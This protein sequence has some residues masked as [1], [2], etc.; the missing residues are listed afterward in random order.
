MAVDAEVI[1]IGN[2]G[3]VV[4]TPVG[5]VA[6]D[7]LFG[8]GAGEY[9]STPDGLIDAVEAARAP[10]DRIDAL[11][12]THFHPDHFDQRAV[13][14]YLCARRQTRLIST[15]Q[16]CAMIDRNDPS[17]DE[18]APRVTAT[19][20]PAGK[21]RT[22]L[23]AGIRVDVFRIS[24]GRV[25]FGNVEQVGFVVYAG[26]LSFLHLGDGI[27]DEKGLDAV[28]VLEER[29]DA[30]FLPFWYLTHE[31]GKRLMESRLKPRRVFAVHIPPSEQA[32]IESAIAGFMPDA[33]ALVRPMAT[34]TIT[35]NNPQGQL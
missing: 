30:A 1:F 32:A 25:N 2:E 13:A 22:I 3:V 5:G 8:R 19:F 27:I 23:V 20:P 33:T 16:A 10:F 35:P 18:I 11:L 14:R 26:G 21:R 34:Y 29:I 28:G 17:W 31:Y 15:P 24:H 12:A 9:T 7:A 6:I 4:S